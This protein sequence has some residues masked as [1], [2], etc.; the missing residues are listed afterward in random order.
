[1]NSTKSLRALDSNTESIVVKIDQKED[2]T[3]NKLDVSRFVN[4]KSLVVGDSTCNY[5]SGFNVNGMQQLETIR[6]GINSLR[7]KSYG[8]CTFSVKKCSSLKEIMIEQYSCQSHKSVIIE[9]NPS[10]E[11]IGIGLFYYDSHNFPGTS[12]E[13]KSLFLALTMMNRL[14]QIE[15]TGYWWR[16]DESLSSSCI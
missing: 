2:Y 1:M 7:C 13:L 6:I 3:F 11:A 15:I 14:A 16:C 12:F 8:S 4:L 5:L 10:L 9:D